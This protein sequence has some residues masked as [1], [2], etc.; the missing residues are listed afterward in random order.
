MSGK[1]MI[2][3][4]S[5]MT[6]AVRRWLLGV[7]GLSLAALTTLILIGIGNARSTPVMRETTLHLA[8]LPSS[9]R[10]LKIA[11]LAD[12]HLGNRGMTPERL[13]EIISEVNTSQPDLILLAGDFVTGHDASGAA[14]RAAGLTAPFARLRAPLGV[15][16]V[17]GNHDHWTAPDAVRAALAE[18]G[19]TV[20][21]NQ[22]V[23]RGPFAI[24]GIGDRFSGHDDAPSSLAAAHSIGGVPI[25]LT[26]SPDIAPDLP[27]SQPL[28]LAGHT[29]CGQVVLPWIGPLVM[30]APSDHWRQLYNPRYRCGIV[31]DG[32]RTTV[33]TAG[34]GSGTFPLRLGALPDWWLITLEP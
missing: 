4:R 34:V 31:R 30:Y 8:G 26:H 27:A 17:L 3:K 12:I 28:V 5:R 15:L 7:I 29:H 21:E 20:L 6:R 10:S 2:G 16:A 22:A 25:V 9:S 11:L 14:D 23:R 19:V 13:G 32:A 18:A 1:A 24:V 33:V